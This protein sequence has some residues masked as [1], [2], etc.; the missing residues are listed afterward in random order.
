MIARSRSPTME[1]V[2]IE[3]RS[4]RAWSA[5]RT[6]VLP[7]WTTYFGPRTE[8]PGSPVRSARSPENQ[9]A[10][11]WRQGAASRWA[12]RP[13]GSRYTRRS[14][15][16]GSLRAFARG[17][18]RTRRKIAR[19]PGRTLPRVFLL[20][21]VAVKNS[22]K[23]HAARSPARAIASGRLSKPARVRSR[24]GI[25]PCEFRPCVLTL[26]LTVLGLPWKCS[27]P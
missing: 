9:K 18:P 23:R 20:R 8:P 2:L 27:G 7:R 15:P 21:I 25:F 11:G 24:F 14:P 4:V 26:P 17:A 3:S 22:M 6:G 19:P 1:S 5:F 13:D 10:S 16:D 12:P